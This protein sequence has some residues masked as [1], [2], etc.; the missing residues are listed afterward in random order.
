MAKAFQGQKVL[1]IG[2]GNTGAEIALDLHEYGAKP[3]ISIR[4]PINIIAR[5][6]NGRPVQ[7]TAKKLE[8]LP[9][10]L[11][12]WLAVIITKFTIGD[13]SKYGIVRPKISPTKQLLM[14]GKTPVIDIG[15][16][17][18]IKKGNIKILHDIDYFYKKGVAFKDGQQLDFDAVILATGYRAKVED[19]VEGAEQLL[20]KFEV[21]NRAVLD[22]AFEGLYF[23]GFD[24][25]KLGGILG[26]IYDDSE[27]IV[28][29]I[30][31]K[32]GNY[33]WRMER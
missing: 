27:I 28:A 15:T 4:G 17:A 11:K 26:T 25:Y 18:E 1:V 33:E 30:R 22:G 2:M 31:S 21:P 16:V 12:E 29:D 13:L 6:V 14:Y 32:I 20:D 9:E 5:D 8:K 24:N 23:L 10:W 3:F 19:F 7:V